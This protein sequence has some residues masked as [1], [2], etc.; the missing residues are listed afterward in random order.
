MS[1]PI[2]ELLKLGTRAR[3]MRLPVCASEFPGFDRFSCLPD[4]LSIS[5]VVLAD[6]T[7]RSAELSRADGAP[8]ERAGSL[9]HSRQYNGWGRVPSYTDHQSCPG[10]CEFR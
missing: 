3:Y 1:Q 6:W 8:S 9:P 5:C 7:G 2:V 4:L 10:Y